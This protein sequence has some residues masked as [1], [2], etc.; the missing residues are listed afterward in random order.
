MKTWPNSL[1]ARVEERLSTHEYWRRRA[2]S[3]F[4]ESERHNGIHLAVFVEPFLQF[5]LDGRK[6]VESRF[7]MYRT[8]PFGCVRSRDVVLVK[9]SGG[10]VVAI[11][12][13]SRVWYYE[14]DAKAWDFIRKR[15]AAQL[16]IDGSEFWQK[17]SSSYFATLMQFGSVEE[18]DP[19]PCSKRD[20]RGW[21][22]LNGCSQQRALPLN[23]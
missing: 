22:V 15:F 19:V 18:L 8:P 14:L 4:A 23:T 20:R 11:A 17:K 16:C 3:L 6:T 10:P 13:I 1:L 21:V 9:R 2:D 5:V 7:S 12:E